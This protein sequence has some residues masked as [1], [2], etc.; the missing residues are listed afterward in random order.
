[1]NFRV[2]FFVTSV[3]S[4]LEFQKELRRGILSRSFC[5][6]VNTL[7]VLIFHWITEL[8]VMLVHVTLVVVIPVFAFKLIPM[9]GVWPWPILLF[10]ITGVGGLTLSMESII[11]KS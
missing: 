5:A 10:G 2:I 3:T 1:M 8:L 4:G 9:D 11:I 7:E 6:G